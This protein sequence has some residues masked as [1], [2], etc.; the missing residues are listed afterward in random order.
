VRQGKPQMCQCAQAEIIFLK[1]RWENF[2]NH[3]GRFDCR[4]SQVGFCQGTAKL[5]VY[6]PSVGGRVGR[7]TVMTNVFQLQEGGDFHHPASYRD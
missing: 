7:L 1:V 6:R 3:L 5:S 2:K 4:Q